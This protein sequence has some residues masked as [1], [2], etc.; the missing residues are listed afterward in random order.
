MK[1]KTESILT[2]HAGTEVWF[3]V[4]GDLVIDSPRGQVVIN[5]YDIPEFLAFVSVGSRDAGRD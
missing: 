5:R 4:D 3:S 2:D 1:I